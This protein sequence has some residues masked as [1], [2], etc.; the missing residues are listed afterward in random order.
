MSYFIIS[1]NMIKYNDNM[2]IVYAKFEDE[3]KVILTTKT[4]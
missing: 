4:N 2:G 1:R 3:V